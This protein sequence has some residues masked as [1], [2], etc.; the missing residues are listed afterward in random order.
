M[1]SFELS[2]GYITWGPREQILG[3]HQGMFGDAASD[4]ASDAATTARAVAG[5]ELIATLTGLATGLIGVVVG[6]LVGRSVGDHRP[7]VTAGSAVGGGL[8]T[9]FGGYFLMRRLRMTQIAADV[10]SRAA[11]KI[12]RAG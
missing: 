9:G 8:A 2:P 1:Q 7:L 5:A 3:G 11:E 4:A 10:A 12:D 6:G